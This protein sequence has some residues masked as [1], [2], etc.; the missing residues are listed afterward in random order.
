VPDA[1]LTKT[2]LHA[3]KWEGLLVLP[4][5]GP[6]TDVVG[7]EIEVLL[8][9]API[10]GVTVEALETPGEYAIVIPI[11]A[12]SIAD[13]V[14]VFLIR[15]RPSNAVLNAFAIL[16]GDVLGDTLHTEVLLLRAELDMLK[17]AFRRHC[18]ETLPQA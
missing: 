7:T 5:A 2:R 12:E 16:S 3:G 8:H 15:H 18:V 10:R 11:P 6:E 17:R 9:D 13:G 14:Q 4:G 1:T